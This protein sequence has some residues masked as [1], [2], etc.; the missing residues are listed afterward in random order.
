MEE[1]QL[2]LGLLHGQLLGRVPVT[3]IRLAQRRRPNSTAGLKSPGS[4]S[5]AAQALAG[6]ATGEVATRGLF[7]SDFQPSGGCSRIPEDP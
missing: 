3:P 4:K 2:E 5:V 6:L 7:H 1:P